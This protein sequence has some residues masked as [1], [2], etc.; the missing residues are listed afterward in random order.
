MKILIADDEVVSRRTLEATLLKWGYEV[1]VACDGRDAWRILQQA[2][3]PKLAILDWMMPGR[4]GVDICRDLRKREEGLYTYVLL[5]TS[6]AG[7]HD[8]IDGLDAGADDYVT[9]P[10][11]P[12]ELKVRLRAGCRILHLQDQLVAAREALREQATHDPLTG[13]WNH[14][15]ILGILAGEVARAQREG[16]SVGVV[17]ADLDRFKCIN[18]VHGHLAGDAVL[19]ETARRIRA[20]LRPY[21]EVGRYGG[22]EFLIVAPGCDTPDAANLAERLRACVVQEPIDT[23]EGE[24]H[25]TMSLG[26]TTSGGSEPT[27]VVRLIGSADA[28]LYRAKNEGRNRVVLAAA[29]PD[30]LRPTVSQQNC[31]FVR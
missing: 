16:S 18:D 11:D 25:V 6:K 14:G 1:A 3:A 5:L 22:E 4:D 13:L 26:V 7:R 9:K 17:M 2:G 23:A 31:R 29:G 24:L 28:A 19:R 15:A 21:D 10:F 8:M 12:Q 30:D 27:D 20:S